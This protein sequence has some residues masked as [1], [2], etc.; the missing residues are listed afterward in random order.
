M[1]GKRYPR[2]PSAPVE[3]LAL[4]RDAYFQCVPAW[5]KRVDFEFSAVLRSVLGQTEHEFDAKFQALPQMS[6]DLL[7][8]WCSVAFSRLDQ[9]LAERGVAAYHAVAV[10]IDTSGFRTDRANRAMTRRVCGHVAKEII[11]ELTERIFCD[12]KS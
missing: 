6:W 10:E 1:N 9:K 8:P 12:H 3:H 4:F 2:Y 11:T 7:P 5:L